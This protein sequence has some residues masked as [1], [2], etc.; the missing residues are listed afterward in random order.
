M[1]SIAARGWRL[2][3]IPGDHEPRHVHARHGGAGAP[4]AVFRLNEDRSITLRG[5]DG[6]LTHAQVRE[7]EEIVVMHFGEL[8]ELWEMYC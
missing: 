6:Q 4:E 7:A 3:V 2:V 8:E 1:P 5:A